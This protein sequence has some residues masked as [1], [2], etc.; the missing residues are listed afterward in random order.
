MSVGEDV[1]HE[2]CFVQAELPPATGRGN[3]ACSTT[4]CALG[5]RGSARTFQFGLPFFVR[6]LRPFA[7]GTAWNIFCSLLRQH[8]IPL[9]SSVADL[10]SVAASAVPPRCGIRNI[11]QPLDVAEL[12]TA[13]AFEL[14][15]CEGLDAVGVRSSGSNQNSQR[16][17][18]GWSQEFLPEQLG[19]FVSAVRQAAGGDTPIGVGLPLGAHVEDLR[20]ALRAGIDF[21][22]LTSRFQTLEADDVRSVMQCRQL[23]REMECDDLPILVSPPRINWDQAH[24]LLALGASAV[25]IDSLLRPL[26]PAAP[27]TVDDLG[28][29]ML[30]S[31]TPKASRKAPELTTM[32]AAL[33][34]AR[35][36]LVERLQSCGAHDLKNFGAHVLRSC[37]PRATQLTGIPP[38]KWSDAPPSELSH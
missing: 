13:D 4:T 28:V 38:L 15:C 22:S 23:T 24:K 20:R 10:H 8:G 35:L 17:R 34:A 26:I 27:T 11:N 5:V 9:F 36:E 12:T 30:S 33:D 1:L 37:S 25:C 3:D 19:G 14:A 29:G 7:V 32:S 31:L 16:Q 21:I 2:L 18:W 6:G